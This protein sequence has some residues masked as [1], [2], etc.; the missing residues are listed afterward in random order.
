MLAIFIGLAHSKRKLLLKIQGGWHGV[1]PWSLVAVKSEAVDPREAIECAGIPIEIAESIITVPFNDTQRLN[2]IFRSL[3][4]QIGAVIAEL[5]IGN[6]GMEMASP[7]FALSLRANCNEFGSVLILDEIV[8][9]FRCGLG[10]LASH[11]GIEADIAT[12]GKTISG[13]MPFAAIV[14]RKDVLSCVNTRNLP[15]AVVDVGTFT[16][17]PATLKLV[18]RT[19]QELETYH[20]TL[21]PTILRHA[22]SMRASLQLLFDK[23]RVPAH[24]T[25]GSPSPA[26][27][28]F[29][30][31]TVRFLVD[32]RRYDRNRA[33]SHWDD[34]VVDTELRDVLSRLAL[35]VR[36]YFPW[37]GAGVITAVHT[38][39]HIAGFL[40]AYEDWLATWTF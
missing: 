14:G 40:N 19:L 10:S 15:R 1:Q 33:L 25:G 27:P 22:C 24:V 29:P 5:V 4:P 18:L 11:Y 38:K 17:H 30:I 20:D 7:E 6:S 37:Q 3:G 12:F 34:M 13:G 16:S 2:D 8:T 9:G 31:M 26:I 23:Y 28:G 39:E 21:Y 36:G 32:E 35:C